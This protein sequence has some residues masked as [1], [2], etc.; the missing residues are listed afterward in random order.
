MAICYG[1]LAHT[2]D[3]WTILSQ[4][5]VHTPPP[6]PPPTSHHRTNK[7]VRRQLKTSSSS[8]RLE[9]TIL[10]EKL[11]F[12]HAAEARK[13][14]RDYPKLDNLRGSTPSL[15][16]SDLVDLHAISKMAYNTHTFGACL[17]LLLQ[18][19]DFRR[20]LLINMGTEMQNVQK[21]IRVHR[22]KVDAPN[23]QHSQRTQAPNLRSTQTHHSTFLPRGP[24]SPLYSY[25]DP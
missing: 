22:H 14:E 16:F 12:G 4:I 5:D 18:P 6:P 17:C 8:Q 13:L 9:K 23:F 19:W 20:A 7:E 11:C 24:E 2:T 21:R 3:L 25:L 1:G 15:R 10:A